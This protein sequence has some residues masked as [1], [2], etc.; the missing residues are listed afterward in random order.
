MKPFFIK[1]MFTVTLALFLVACGSSADDKELKTLIVSTKP[2]T[3]TLYFNDIIEPLQINSATAAFDG[4]VVQ[5]NFDY[6]E[7]VKKNQLLLVIN[8]SQFEDSFQEALGS[9]L[10]AKKEYADS[11]SKMQS[12]EQLQKLG[13]ISQDE[14][15]ST[16]NQV[17]NNK[18]SL[19]Q[20]T[21]KLENI[22][23]KINDSSLSSQNIINDTHALEAAMAE[24]SSNQLKIVAPSDGIV[25]LPIKSSSSDGD[26]DKPLSVGSQVKAGQVVFNI[27]DVSGLTLSVKVNSY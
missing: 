17:Y 26:T 24:H 12:T 6:G 21:R 8:S 20:Y 4:T 13:I 19:A 1:I 18:L 23:G 2:N 16:T 5:K 3:N 9:F 27:G 14:Y 22:L 11:Q 10:K 25:L 7:F 15:N